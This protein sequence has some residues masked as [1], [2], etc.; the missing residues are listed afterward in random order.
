[1]TILRRGFGAMLLLVAGW[2]A[3]QSLAAIRYLSQ[4]TGTLD[5]VID[6]PAFLLPLAA[7]ALAWHGGLFA[8]LALPGGG[9]VGLV[10]GVLYALYGGAILAMGGDQSMWL[11]KLVFGSVMIV[12][13]LGLL[14]MPRRAG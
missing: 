4:Q 6:D 11:P 13:S 14:R 1:M 10:G 7:S 2:L 3:W 8:L 12:L 5:G 9:V